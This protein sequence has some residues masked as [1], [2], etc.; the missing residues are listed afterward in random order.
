MDAVTGTQGRSALRR[1]A[2]AETRSEAS[3]RSRGKVAT[4]VGESLA[5]R[6]GEAMPGTKWVVRGTLGQGGMGVVLD[7]VKADFIEGAMKV[8]RPAFAKVPEF[9]AG[10]L[11]E[12]KVTAGLKHTNIVQVL[13]FDCC[14]PPFFATGFSR[15]VATG[16]DGFAAM[17]RPRAARE[18]VT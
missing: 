2:R 9:A 6:V 5:Y 1:V 8:L 4:Q 12:A 10:F 3:G 11:E 7:V 15:S 14:L 17:G 18:R 16:A 13:D